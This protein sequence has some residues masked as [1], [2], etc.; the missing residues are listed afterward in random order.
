MPGKGS[1]RDDYI[2]SVTVGG[3]A[4]DLYS[5]HPSCSF[6]RTTCYLFIRVGDYAI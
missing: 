4:P 1:A 3:Q 2:D 6:E 5:H